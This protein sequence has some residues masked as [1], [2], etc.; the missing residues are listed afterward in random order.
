MSL[1]EK[2][3]SKLAD[4]MLSSDLTIALARE[5]AKP[6]PDYS[7]IRREIARR[8]RAAEVCSHA[9]QLDAAQARVLALGPA[10]W[11]GPGAP[12]CAKC[13]QSIRPLKVAS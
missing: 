13:G 5:S 11:I 2:L 6:K 8:S 12:C 7:A 9:Y 4:A 3:R 10:I 1:L